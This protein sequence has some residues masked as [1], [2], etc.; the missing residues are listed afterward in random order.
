MGNSKVSQ[1]A[2]IIDPSLREEVRDGR[3]YFFY[4]P[5]GKIALLRFAPLALLSLIVTGGAAWILRL[6]EADYY[7]FF[8]TPILCSLPVM[9]AL[10]GALRLGR[11]RNQRVGAVLGCTLMMFFYLGYWHLSYVHFMINGSREYGLPATRAELR[12]VSGR[13]DHIG[14]F[15]YRNRTDVIDSEGTKKEHDP[16]DEIFGYIFRGMEFVMLVGLGIG[17]GVSQSGRVFLEEQRRWAKRRDFLISPAMVG[18]VSR[19]ITDGKWEDLGRIDRVLAFG[20]QDKLRV[21]L[22]F[23]YLPEDMSAPTFVSLTGSQLGKLP[24]ELAAMGRKSFL[25]HHFLEQLRV[26]PSHRYTIATG[27]PE[28]GMTASPPTT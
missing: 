15:I 6:A 23:E 7:Y 22:S 4:Q 25:Q 11:C 8:F 19:L 17:I 3:Q 10:W 20:R 1:G 16:A 12:Q 14:Y 28:L 9:G 21:T 26:D 27:F 5:S 13:S 2:P 24:P 18:E